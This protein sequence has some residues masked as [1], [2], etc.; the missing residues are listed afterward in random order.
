MNG[1]ISEEN[2]LTKGID[3]IRSIPSTIIHGRYDVICP[4]HTAYHLHTIWPE[5]DYIVVP[6]SGHSSLDDGVRTRLIEATENAKT[7]R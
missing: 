6:D 4:I 3:K 7:L 5:A 1:V 2:S